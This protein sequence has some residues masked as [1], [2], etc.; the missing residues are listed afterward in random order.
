MT[1]ASALPIK[2]AACCNVRMLQG[3]A[4]G[5]A[6]AA[7][8]KMKADH[9]RVSKI[10]QAVLA[11]ALGMAQPSVSELL[12]FG[13]LAKEKVPVLLEYFSDV[14]GPDHFGLPFSKF[15]M[16]LI[17][18]MRKLP[19]QSQRALLERV[20]KS[21]AAVQQVTQDIDAPLDTEFRKPSDQDAA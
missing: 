21:A 16:D 17:N 6:I 20:M 11:S 15:E 9:M 14:A 2:G 4:L 12:K 13:R 3:P 10:T 18:E 5:S 19:L 1:A 7:A 8:M